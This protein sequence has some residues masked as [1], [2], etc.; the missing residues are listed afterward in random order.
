MGTD[1]SEKF[2]V[3]LGTWLLTSLRAQNRKVETE[4]KPICPPSPVCLLKRISRKNLEP[5]VSLVSPL[6][7]GHALALHLADRRARLPVI[8][9]K[10]LGAECWSMYA[11]VVPTSACTVSSREKGPSITMARLGL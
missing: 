3:S 10:T 6:F 8:Q 5:Q 11:I 2:F 1:F 7:R 9:S 4:L